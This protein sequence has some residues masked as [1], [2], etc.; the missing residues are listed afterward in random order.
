MK[1]RIDLV[2]HV[3]IPSRRVR[4][5]GLQ[6]AGREGRAPSRGGT[7]VAMYNLLL[8]VACCL[9]V[10][11]AS[12]QKGKQTEAPSWQNDLITAIQMDDVFGLSQ[13]SVNYALPA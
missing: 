8:I 10:S 7:S 6:D 1:T 2:H 3:I 4:A 12:P 11:C 5:R 13:V 9:L